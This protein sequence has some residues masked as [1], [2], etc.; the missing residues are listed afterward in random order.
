MN[1]NKKN[2]NYII[3]NVTNHV[4]LLFMFVTLTVHVLFSQTYAVGLWNAIEPDIRRF[5]KGSLPSFLAGKCTC[6]L[7]CVVCEFM[8]DS[9]V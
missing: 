8:H 6:V 7:P 9:P 2:N 3:Y 4:N 5:P 1:Q